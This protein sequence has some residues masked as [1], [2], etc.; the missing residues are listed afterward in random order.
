[1]HTRQGLARLDRVHAPVAGSS[2]DGDV[3]DDA[4][5]R[6]WEREQILLGLVRDTP[7]EEFARGGLAALSIDPTLRIAVLPGDP[8]GQPVPAENPETVIP[9]VMTLPGG[10]Q[11]P[12]HGTVRGTSSGYV[13]CTTGDDDRWQ[14]FSAVLWHGGVDVFPGTHG[15]RTWEVRPGSPRRVI[16]LRRCVGWAWAAFDLQRQMVERYGVAGPYRVILGIADTA[17]ALL[18]NVGAG[19]AE[20]GAP[21][22][23]DLPTAIEPRV[24]LLEDLA[25]WPD[26][27]G[28]EELA[29]RLGARVDLA[30]GGPGTRHLDRTGPDAGKFVPRW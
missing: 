14:S 9:K 28:V 23:W 17:G 27:K 1:M 22:V 13:G 16:Y 19:W 3:D 5:E 29:L 25:E 18:G 21:G 6:R 12:Y 2:G 10:V 7:N 24:L 30:F 26:E 8:F 15:G 20:P 11:F 4:V